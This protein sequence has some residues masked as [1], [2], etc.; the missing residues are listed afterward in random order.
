MAIVGNRYWIL[1]ALLTAAVV[2]YGAGFIVGLGL[3]VAAGVI[4]EL[5]FWL[6]LFNRRHQLIRRF[7][8]ASRREPTSDKSSWRCQ[9]CREDNPGE[10]ELCW[11]CGHSPSGPSDAGAA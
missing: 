7:L 3:F 5:A 6:E 10:F 1:L 9:A 4:F 8:R 2:S 11:N